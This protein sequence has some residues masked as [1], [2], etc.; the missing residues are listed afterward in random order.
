[1]N[2]RLLVL[3]SSLTPPLWLGGVVLP[4]KLF[5]APTGLGALHAA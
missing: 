2:D 1:M 4:A 5:L 3:S